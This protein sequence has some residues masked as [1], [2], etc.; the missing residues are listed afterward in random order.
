MISTGLYAYKP[1]DLLKAIN[2]NYEDL[3]SCEISLHYQ[4]F[5]GLNGTEVVE[6]YNSIYKRD[7]SVTYRKIFQTELIGTPDYQLNVNHDNQLIML[8]NPTKINP[9]DLDLATVLKKCQDIN[10]VNAENGKLI[11]LLFKERTDVP[12]S[13]IK[14]YVDTQN[15]IQK[16]EMMSSIK[17]DFSKDY[18]EKDMDY[19]K[20]TVHYG[21]LRKDVS[22]AVQEALPNRFFVSTDSTFTL[23]ETY[24]NYRLID[25]RK[26]TN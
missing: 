24:K 2:K 10:V 3:N 20:L 23:N 18:F 5:R 19:P 17:M 22:K 8:S 4:L 16:I 1:I 6:E 13:F 26:L 14:I 7:N 11:I 12:Y 15:W 9:V 25:L 21:T